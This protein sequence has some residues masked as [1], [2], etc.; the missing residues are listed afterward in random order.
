MGETVRSAEIE[1]AII[2]GLS[3]GIPLTV[4]CRDLGIGYSTVGLWQRNDEQFASDIARARDAGWDNI[5]FRSRDVARGGEGSTGDV[6]RDK[7]IID[8]DLKLLAKWDKRYADTSTTKHEG[9]LTLTVQT[10]VP[11]ANGD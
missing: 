7:L 1:N 11:E 3:E 5:A 8:T 10:G 4:I 6:Q 2:L 9:G